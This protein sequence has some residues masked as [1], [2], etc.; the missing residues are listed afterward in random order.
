MQC[1]QY[2]PPPPCHKPEQDHRYCKK[3]DEYK[4]YDGGGGGVPASKDGLCVD[5]AV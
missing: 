2:A 5:V 3:T 4:T 1:V